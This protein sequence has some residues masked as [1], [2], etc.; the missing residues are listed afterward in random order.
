MRLSR[1]VVNLWLGRLMQMFKRMLVRLR[2]CLI[3]VSVYLPCGC[4]AVCLLV[5]FDFCRGQTRI[6]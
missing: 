3:S 5:Q 4:Q 2:V 1:N 6:N